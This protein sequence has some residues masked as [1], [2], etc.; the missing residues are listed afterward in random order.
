MNLMFVFD[1]ALVTSCLCLFSCKTVGEIQG[2]RNSEI[3][4]L[5]E[6]KSLI[7]PQKD[8]DIV[9]YQFFCISVLPEKKFMS[10]QKITYYPKFC[11]DCDKY[12]YTR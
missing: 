1:V 4:F 9:S 11:H 6:S 5:L 3:W 10:K 2:F 7:F 12:N 8:C